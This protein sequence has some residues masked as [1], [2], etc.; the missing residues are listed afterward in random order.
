MNCCE[1]VASFVGVGFFAQMI[2]YLWHSSMVSLSYLHFYFNLKRNTQMIINSL[3]SVNIYFT[4][5]DSSV[6]IVTC[7][8]LY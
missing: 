6:Y 2:S 1:K 4:V 5:S 3:H 8:S 7:I